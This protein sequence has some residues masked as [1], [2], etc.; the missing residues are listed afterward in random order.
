MAR[1]TLS[2]LLLVSAAAQDACDAADSSDDPVCLLQLRGSEKSSWGPGVHGKGDEDDPFAWE[3]PRR[4]KSKEYLEERRK[5]EAEMGLDDPP[6][7]PPKSKEPAKPPAKPAKSKSKG[8]KPLAPWQK[9]CMHDSGTAKD[10]GTA[11][12]FTGKKGNSFTGECREGKNGVMGCRGTK[13]MGGD[14]G[15]SGGKG[16][17][18][19]PWVAV[20]DGKDSGTACAFT[21]K[22]GNSLTG[23]CLEGKKNGI[24][25]C[26]ETK[27]EGGGDKGESGGKG[28]SNDLSK[29]SAEPESTKEEDP[30]AWE[31][32]KKS[33]AYLKKAREGDP[34][35]LAMEDE[36]ADSGEDW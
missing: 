32:P 21:G 23:K 8:E 16:E 6:K 33:E 31:P 11:C 14:K 30:F 22:K 18:A 1:G 35:L 10:S 27:K 17:S 36:W 28:D 24:M 29:L 2:I 9:V 7:D 5:E 20:C 25:G 4:E 34:S 12:E 3:P 19:P 26:R 15:E 13:Q